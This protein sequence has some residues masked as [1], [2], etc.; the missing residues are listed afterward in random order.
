[1]DPLWDFDETGGD[2]RFAIDP[3]KARSERSKRPV[4]SP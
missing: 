2:P 1:M 3:N 4:V